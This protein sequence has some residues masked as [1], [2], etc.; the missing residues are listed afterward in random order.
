[1][2]RRLITILW[3][4]S[5][6]ILSAA[7]QSAE[8]D[9]AFNRGIELYRSGDFAESARYFEQADALDRAQLDTVN[10]VRW[11]YACAWAAHCHFLLGDKTKARQMNPYGYEIEPVDRRLSVQS[12][13]LSEK[14]AKNLSKDDY[15]QAIKEAEKTLA[16]EIRILGEDN[17]NVVGSY[18]TLSDLTY[19]YGDLDM[20]LKYIKKAL[21]CIKR[22]SPADEP[23]LYYC[24]AWRYADIV[25]YCT[26]A[27]SDDKRECLQ[28]LRDAADYLAGLGDV[29]FDDYGSALAYLPQLAAELGEM[30]VADEADGR[31]SAFWES[32]PQEKRAD[33]RMILKQRINFCI[34]M[35]QLDITRG[36]DN[37]KLTA[38]AQTYANL[39]REAEGE[40]SEAYVEALMLS[41]GVYQ[42]LS[43]YDEAMEDFER[44]IRL[45]K[46]LY[47][48]Q[49]L[50]VYANIY[51]PMAQIATGSNDPNTAIAHCNETL[52]L[53]NIFFPSDVAFQAQVYNLL[54]NNYNIKQQPQKALE[55]I[56][57][58]VRLLEAANM[59]YT[60]VFADVSLAYA[61]RLTTCN[62]RDEALS[63]TTDALR[64]LES[65]G[66]ER[67]IS[68][69]DAMICRF[70]LLDG[71][72]RYDEAEKARQNALE[73]RESFGDQADNFTY[74][75]L[76]NRASGLYERS[77][78][79]EALEVCNSMLADYGDYA[80][81]K[82]L[83]AK[84]L[85]G[86]HRISEAMQIYDEIIEY[87]SES[88]RDNLA[89]ADF[90]KE[91]AS[92]Y[93]AIWNVVKMEETFDSALKIYRRYLGEQ[94]PQYVEILLGIANIM[95][96]SL[97]IDKG[98]SY[99]REAMRI[100]NKGI[101]DNTRL[102]SLSANII[103]AKLALQKGD[104]A[105]AVSLAESTI[106]G[107]DAVGNQIDNMLGSAYVTLGNAQLN[108]GNYLAADEAFEKALTIL[109]NPNGSRYNFNCAIVFNYQAN[110]RQQMGDYEGA[111][112][113]RELAGDITIELSPK[114]SASY[115][116][117]LMQ[118]AL[119]AWNA[120]DSENAIVYFNEMKSLIDENIDKGSSVQ[121]TMLLATANFE[122]SMGQTEKARETA[123][124]LYDGLKSQNFYYPDIH[125]QAIQ[126][127]FSLVMYDEALDI[128]KFSEKSIRQLFG[129]T[130]PQSSEIF[131]RLTEIYHAIGNMGKVVE[132]IGK[133]FSTGRDVLLGAFTTM[134]QEERANFWNNYY[135]FFR[136]GLPYA[137]YTNQTLKDITKTA[138]NGTL[139]GTG[140][141]LEAE[142]NLSDMIARDGSESLRSLYDDFRSTKAQFNHLSAQLRNFSG[143]DLLA[144]SA[145]TD[146]LSSALNVTERNLLAQVSTELGDF[147]STLRIEW[148]DVR[149][150]LRNTDIAIEFIEFYDNDSIITAALCLKKDFKEPK[151]IK[152]LSRAAT[153]TGFADDCY[154]DTSLSQKI[155]GTLSPTIADAVNIYF[156]TQGAL[157]NV[158][159]ESMPMDGIISDAR[160]RRF[161]RLSSTREL[162]INRKA[163]ATNDAV[164]F[165]GLNYDMTVD[166]MKADT[167]NY[168]GMKRSGQSFAAGLRGS[169]GIPPLP[170]TLKEIEQISSVLSNSPESSFN[171]QKIKGNEG[172]ETAFKQLSGGKKR[173]IHIG[174]HGYYVTA[175]DM[176]HD[177]MLMQMFG[178][179]AND[180]RSLEDKILARSGLYFSGAANN[181][182]ENLSSVDGLLD[183]GVLTAQ[184]ISVLDFSDLDMI[185]LSACE[186]ARGDLS[187]DGVF[188]LQRGFKKAGAG[189]ILMSLWK[190]DDD[191]TQILMTE[192]YRNLADKKSKYESLELAKDKLKADP[193]YNDPDYWA[194]FILLDAIN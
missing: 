2:I 157:C 122:Y 99:Y 144:A 51:Y 64:Y 188:G 125:P 191:A 60:H 117:A 96:E 147:T 133:T 22:L 162:A 167:A 113:L 67:S 95:L 8:S 59:Q 152:V 193:I 28:I 114:E 18:S 101:G 111:A 86:M 15:S 176:H 85:V 20:S 68:Y 44:S 74:Q 159:I 14:I 160:R 50:P 27:T 76:F 126:L 1:M 16:E 84:T 3:L 131:Y 161:H 30:S 48:E 127:F 115:M 81:T 132:Y 91:K 135:P 23:T 166:E 82:R 52:R 21:S 136:Q 61:D 5:A 183:D 107:K 40:Y 118:K 169:L 148:T 170:G 186:T 57:Q 25:N 34:L 24:T 13:I 171:V 182:K 121:Y 123:K 58:A 100:L 11:Q 119:R 168:P 90:L 38:Y 47:G 45:L 49:D 164:L 26:T 54:S 104:F 102:Y 155:W 194:A 69:I 154:F 180:T 103:G 62:R 77:L 112:R 134:T 187:G 189:S 138:Y 179:S 140:I 94:S 29:Y 65:T 75:I 173:I 80:S 37:E 19:Q 110:V 175:D 17:F 92:A 87:S 141:L 4:L 88:D 43:Q 97:V 108:L 153:D 116:I 39:T 156:S 78:F 165:G 174:T 145:Q 41:A 10:S 56:E 46:F 163:P 146:S 150:A 181:Y 53:A 109:Q 130:S 128:A 35:A 42:F 142:R 151:F 105:S 72:G 7:A 185:V 32:I 9:A 192:F 12:D 70:N 124:E 106:A 71:L 63:V 36:S 143:D 137:C 83:R 33:Y 172:T 120:G 55:Y 178:E 98:E 190:V 184:E 6:G 158:A 79:E 93:L 129:A 31:L 66:Q 139:L 73:K 177:N 149:S 89:Y